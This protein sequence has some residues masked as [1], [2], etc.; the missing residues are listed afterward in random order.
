MPVTAHDLAAALPDIGTL[1][2]RCRALATL[3][4]I[5]GGGHHAFD[6]DWQGGQLASMDNGVGDAYAIVFSPA[7]V[8]VRGFDHESPMS[9]WATDEGLWPGLVDS[10]PAVFASCVDEPAFGIDD[11]PAMT[12]CLW[13]EPG[14][15]RWHTG[16]IDFPAGA[17]PDGADWLFQLVV[18]PAGYADFARGYFERD[19][20]PAAVDEIL[21]MRPL[22]AELLKRL[23][24]DLSLAA[25]AADLTEI[26]YPA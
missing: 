7:G 19:V 2:D 17:D 12:V 10:L 3:D 5:L 6:P 24:P 8:F 9:P 18:E 15:D 13:R 23:N 20:D 4:L 16:D 22:T 11:E 26:G 25:P 14:D 21:A 1:R